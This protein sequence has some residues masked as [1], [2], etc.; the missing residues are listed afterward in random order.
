MAVNVTLLVLNMRE[1]PCAIAEINTLRTATL[2]CAVWAGIASLLYVKNLQSSD[3]M[4]CARLDSFHG[5][6][7]V[8]LYLLPCSSN[9]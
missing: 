2:S 6:A 5:A 7:W 8:S 3:G 4:G 1:Q 9:H